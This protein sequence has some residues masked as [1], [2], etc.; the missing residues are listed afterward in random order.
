LEVWLCGNLEG[1]KKIEA[2]V[3]VF[4]NLFGLLPRQETHEPP[5]HDDYVYMHVRERGIVQSTNAV[6][7]RVPTGHLELSS[8]AP[9]T[10][11]S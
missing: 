9:S 8:F 7:I 11:V 2:F 6:T 3:I 5:N 1:M 10:V 4:L